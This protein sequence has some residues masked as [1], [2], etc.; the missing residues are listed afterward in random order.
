[1]GPPRG[2]SGIIMSAPRTRD[3]LSWIIQN[4]WEMTESGYEKVSRRTKDPR[5]H[6]AMFQIGNRRTPSS[7]RQIDVVESRINTSVY[8]P[9][10]AQGRHVWVRN[11]RL[12]RASVRARVDARYGNNTVRCAEEMTQIGGVGH[13]A[14]HGSIKH[15]Q[16]RINTLFFSVSILPSLLRVHLDALSDTPRKYRP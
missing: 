2:P 15:E 13:R 14:A 8:V 4:S 16:A 3:W 9:W 12:V 7:N 10:R 1:M 5:Q 11:E 6:V